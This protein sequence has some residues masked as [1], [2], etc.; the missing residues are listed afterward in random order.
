MMHFFKS[1]AIHV[2]C[3]TK[4]VDVVEYA[5]VDHA[6]KYI[7]KWWKA[8]PKEMYVSPDNPISPT[9]K[10]C[11]GMYDFYSK[12]IC[13]PLWSELS[14]GVHEG[15]YSWQFSDR[16][17]SGIIH[18]PR[19]YEGFMFTGG[20]L[21]IESPWFFSTKEDISWA[22]SHPLYS[23]NHIFDYVVLPGVMEFKHQNATSIQMLINLRENK[24]FRI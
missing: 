6:I 15:R 17:T 16:T 13:L 19:Q 22:V 3:F 20:H 24:T 8:L 7:P 23:S 9:M 5:P 1:S 21:K 10:T 2:D 11:Y 12:S 4:R 18:N 14:I